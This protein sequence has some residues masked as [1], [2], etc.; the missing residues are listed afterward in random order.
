M[1]RA[2]AGGEGPAVGAADQGGVAEVDVVMMA[3]AEGPAVDKVG[4][5]AV[6]EVIEMMGLAVR[7]WHSAAGHDAA[8]TVA[9]DHR[10]LLRRGEEPLESAEIN[11][12]AVRVEDDPTNV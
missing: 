11:H 1:D 9:G 10:P 8:V 12:L 6:V 4:L 2:V 3:G 7:D 5:A